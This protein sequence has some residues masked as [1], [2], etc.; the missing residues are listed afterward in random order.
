[1]KLTEMVDYLLKV[2]LK[3]RKEYA[4]IIIPENIQGKRTLI[5]HLM[6]VREP[7]PLSEEFLTVQDEYLKTINNKITAAEDLKPVP[8]DER[9]FLWQGDIT[10]LKADAIVNAANSQM[11]GCFIPGHGCIDNAIHSM[12]GIQLR[13]E[14]DKLMREQGHLEETGTAKI[15]GA[16]NLPSKYIIHTVGPIISGKLTESD[17]EDLKNC[18]LAT[19]KIAD[20]Y[21]LESVAFCCISTGEFRFPNEE[22]AE[23]AV[24]IVREYLNGSTNLKR[25]IFNV[26]KDKDREIY[27]KL[28]R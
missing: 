5:R 10:T 20:E 17:I 6:N 2:L 28:L 11:L 1:M 27:R 14:C 21:K 7:A 13:L 19:M 18:Y 8:A 23:I 24:R 15:T 9:L 3:E 22:A 16:Y 12:A 26:F 25:V 4:E